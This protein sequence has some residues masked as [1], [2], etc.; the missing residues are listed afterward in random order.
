MK[1]LPDCYK[2]KILVDDFLKQEGQKDV[3]DFEEYR[4][5]K[6]QQKTARTQC[7]NFGKRA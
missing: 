3:V 6:K 2:R 5:L 4:K 1:E 7:E